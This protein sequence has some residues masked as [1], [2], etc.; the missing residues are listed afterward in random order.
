MA[1]SRAPKVDLADLTVVPLTGV[2]WPAYA[3]LMER[4]NGVFGG[5]WCTWF[6]TM[7]AEKTRDAAD[8]RALQERRVRAGHSHAALVMHGDEA[9]AWC[10]FG[11]PAELPN[12]Y[13]RKEYEA[14]GR[15][16]PDYRITCL[17]VDKRYR[18]SA[19]SAVALRGVIHLVA[20]AGGGELEGYPHDA[21]GQRQSVL[22]SGT[23]ELFER[24]GFT[25]VRPKG[26]KNC[27]MTMTVA[28]AG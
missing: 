10:Q 6:L 1:A 20:A 28:P 2:S 11:S 7:P 14:M 25:Y 24:A 23:R 13:H 21:Q 12:I 9:I 17:F 26:P 5:C 3:A 27:V 8:N 18:R 4:H 22:Y 16:L 15:A 19:V